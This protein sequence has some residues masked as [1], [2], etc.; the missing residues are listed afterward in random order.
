MN[1]IFIFLA[2]IKLATAVDA[3]N[4]NA[5]TFGK[6]DFKSETVKLSK[7]IKDFEKY[8][9]TSFVTSGTVK[10]VCQ[11]EGCWFEMADGSDTVRITMKDYGFKV[12]KTILNKNVKVVG[13]LEQKELPVKMVKHYLKDEGQPQSVIDKVTQPQKVFQFIADGVEIL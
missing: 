8:K 5:T 12:P 7:A 2:F 6:P 3:T 10:K 1:F 11:M 9:G 4:V 13:V